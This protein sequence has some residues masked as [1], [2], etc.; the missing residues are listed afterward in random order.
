MTFFRRF[1]WVVAGGFGAACG[2]GLTHVG[3]APSVHCGTEERVQVDCSSFQALGGRVLEVNAGLA[4]IG[5]GFQAK[6][7]TQ[8]LQQVRESTEHLALDLES[9]CRNYNACALDRQSYLDEERRVTELLSRHLRL[10]EQQQ[11]AKATDVGDQLWSN[12]RPDLARERLSLEYRL[13]VR[14]ASGYRTH[15]SGT[16]L[17]SGDEVRFFLKPSREAFVYVL[18]LSSQGTP[19]LL[20]PLPELGL[21]NP[22]P[23]QRELI[24]PPPQS[25]RLVVDQVV[26]TEHLE[27]I[28]SLTQLH[29]L[30]ER[31]ESLRPGVRG[32]PSKGID[33]LQQVG[34]LLCDQRRDARLQ[35]TESRVACDGAATRGLQLLPPATA[36]T[37]VP[38][39][40]VLA[41]EP[42]DEIVVFQHEILHR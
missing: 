11:Q 27:I 34:H 33:L 42:N 6:Y 12:A 32:E 1:A 8:A 17:K 41:A 26:G 37:P 18:L 22:V 10:S 19:S 40:T 7:E 23:A 35:V 20:H 3:P 28:A 31:M 13:E 30:S 24:T 38:T 29:D 5:L 15:I 9:A 25:A 4:K 2:A 16:E 36:A 14:T 21:E 39:S